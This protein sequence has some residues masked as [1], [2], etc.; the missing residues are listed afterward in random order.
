MPYVAFAAPPQRLIGVSGG[1]RI[2]AKRKGRG[3][4]WRSLGPNQIDA[5]LIAI[6]IDISTNAR[7]AISMMKCLCVWHCFR[8]ERETEQKTPKTPG[9]CFD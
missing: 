2:D 8:A 5:G 7:A 4:K 3:L 1:S 9:V 6:D